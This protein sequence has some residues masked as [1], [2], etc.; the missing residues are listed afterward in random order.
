MNTTVFW[1]WQSDSPKSTN[2]LFIQEALEAAIAS[3][4]MDE[5]LDSRPNLDHDVKDLSGA[6]EIFAEVLSKIA[7][8]HVFVADVTPVAVTEGGKPHPNANVMIELGWAMHKPGPR[9]QILVLN[10]GGVFKHRDLP[11]NLR[12]RR[13]I[14]Y[15]LEPNSSKDEIEYQRQNLIDELAKV[16]G[17]SLSERQLKHASELPDVGVPARPRDPSLWEAADDWIEHQSGSMTQ[18]VHL[19]VGP[20]AFLRAIPADWRSGVPS[21]ADVQALDIN[22]FPYPPSHCQSGDAGP[23]S[24]GY[25]SYWFDTDQP[26]YAS[27]VTKFFDETGEFWMTSAAALE[28]DGI[29]KTLNWETLFAGWS[30]TIRRCNRFFNRYGASG[31]RRLMVGVAG[32]KEIRAEPRASSFK[33]RKPDLMVSSTRPHWGEGDLNE[34]LEEAHV[35]MRD[36]FSM[37]PLQKER[38]RQ[39][40]R[41]VELERPLE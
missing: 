7:S 1:S 35:K 13:I 24:D 3:V 32:F 20:R 40:L 21:V 17:L 15:S 39:F 26:R 25:V 22:D 4:G 28:G 41:R 10:E 16:V 31:M 34:F 29:Q 23:T 8:A 33:S 5:K 18:R 9:H 11:F 30:S 38:V 27:D 2:H 37:P 19:L 14:T 12:G 6:P 36:L